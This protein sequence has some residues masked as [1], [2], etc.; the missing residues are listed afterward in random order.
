[1][2]PTAKITANGLLVKNKRVIHGPNNELHVEGLTPELSL[3][4]VTIGAAFMPRQ[5][6]KVL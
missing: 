2:G 6:N 3:V 1:M 4:Y 5:L